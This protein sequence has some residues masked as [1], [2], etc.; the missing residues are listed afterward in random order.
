MRARRQGD[1]DGG[2]VEAEDLVAAAVVGEADE[3]VPDIAV[4]ALC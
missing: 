1:S 2:A 3:V 4:A